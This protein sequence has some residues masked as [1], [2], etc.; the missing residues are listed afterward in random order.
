MDNEGRTFNFMAAA[1]DTGK[2]F[3][4]MARHLPGAVRADLV[5]EYRQSPW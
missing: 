1:K 3:G 4:E 5:A 2:Q